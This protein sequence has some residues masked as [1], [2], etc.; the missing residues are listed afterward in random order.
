MSKADRSRRARDPL[1]LARALPFG[2]LPALVGA[3]ALLAALA[4]AGASAAAGFAEGWR[5]AAS[6]TA[7]VILPRGADVPDAVTQLG[8]LPGI[9][10]A[11]AADPA[12]LARL[13]RPW[14]GD[15]GGI[16]LPALVDLRLNGARVPDLAARVGAAVPGAVLE[17]HGPWAGQI[18]NLAQAVRVVALTVLVLVAVVAAAVVA[19]GAGAGLTARRDAVLLLHEWGARDGEIAGRF[20]RRLALLAGVGASAGVA[21]A[22][23]ALLLVGQLVPGTQGGMLTLPWISLAMVPLLAAGL[24]W[25]VAQAVLRR[26]LR[27][28]P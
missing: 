4:L 25:M 14:L 13:L 2:L 21:V 15:D 27:R 22:L 20:A 1:G 26:W 3:M 18:A 12:A 11:Q 7:T 17:P 9:A 16:A 19:V 23:P 24:G 6:D 28:R 5:S 10:T 8:Q